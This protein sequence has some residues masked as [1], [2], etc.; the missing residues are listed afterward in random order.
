MY[1]LPTSAQNQLHSLES[2]HT[3][4]HKI[5]DVF[6]TDILRQF[7]HNGRFK[8]IPYRKLFSRTED[9][10]IKLKTFPKIKSAIKQTLGQTFI[11]L[12]EY[13]KAEVLL[14]ESLESNKKLFGSNSKES[15]QSTHQLGLCYDWIGNYQLADSFYNQGITIFDKISEKPTKGFAGDEVLKAL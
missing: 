14:L 4:L 12:G 11:G 2:L 7:L 10:E 5:A 9:I 3:W 6:V 8:Y 1:I 15:A 13:K